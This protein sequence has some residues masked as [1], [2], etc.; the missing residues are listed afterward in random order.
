MSTALEQRSVLAASEARAKQTNQAAPEIYADQNARK[1][2]QYMLRSPRTAITPEILPTDETTYPQLHG[3][4]EATPTATLELLTRMVDARALLA[5]LADKAPA[6]PECGSYQVS[7]RY[8]CP[9]CFSYDIDRSFLFEHL[10]CGKV[11]NDSSFRKGDQLVC[12]KCQAVLHNF[13]VEYRAVGAWYQCKACNESF[14]AAASSHFCRPK[15][16]QFSADRARLMP[17]YQYRLNPETLADMRREVLMYNDAVTMLE[18]IGLTVVAPFEVVGKTGQPEYFDIGTTIKGG[19]WSGPKIITIDV[20]AS[21]DTVSIERVREFAAKTK[22]LKPNES[23]LVAVPGL[24]EEAKTFAKNLKVSVIEGPSVK[25]AMSTLLSR[26][27]FKGQ[28]A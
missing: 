1:I 25:E 16:H 11:A 28:A 17:I 3:I 21:G 24:T 14:N 27:I 7:T 8:T 20:N 22:D 18:A 2:L 6:C 4:I 15:R 10:K 26:D 19:R 12:P 9:K 13:G 23:Y 5:D